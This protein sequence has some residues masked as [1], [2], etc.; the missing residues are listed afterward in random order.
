MSSHHNPTNGDLT[1][2]HRMM[3]H[4]GGMQWEDTGASGGMGSASVGG[5]A[6][7]SQIGAIPNAGVGI[8]T[9]RR[10]PSCSYE[11]TADK[12]RFC[13]QC[14]ARMN[15]VAGST[16]SGAMESREEYEDRFTRK[17]HEIRELPESLSYQHITY[18]AVPQARIDDVVAALLSTMRR[19]GYDLFP[20][21]SPLAEE[22]LRGQ[23]YTM[24]GEMLGFKAQQECRRLGERSY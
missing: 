10:C 16:M 21:N 7:L 2:A 9:G 20:E 19:V 13:P 8:V 4:L 24:I 3:R 22:K 6:G 23:F 12:T 17:Q 11:V 1:R 15:E 18:T 14:G 5:D